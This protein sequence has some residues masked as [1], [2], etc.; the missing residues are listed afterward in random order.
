MTVYTVTKDG[1]QATHES[2]FLFSPSSDA[3]ACGRRIQLGDL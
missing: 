2:L 1:V 3:P